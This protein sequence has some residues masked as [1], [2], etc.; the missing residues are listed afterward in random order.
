MISKFRKTWDVYTPG[1]NNT[2]GQSTTK[3]F[4]RK[5]DVA[6]TLYVKSKQENDVRFVDTTHVGFTS[7]KTIASG[8]YLVN[9]AE[10]Y[11]IEYTIP[12]TRWNQLYLRLVV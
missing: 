9:G 4:L 12:N 8:Q 3:T 11:L 6:I 10:T 1:A 2:Y 7:D 5:I